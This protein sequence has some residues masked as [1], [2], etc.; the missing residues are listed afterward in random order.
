MH[1]QKYIDNLVVGDLFY[2]NYFEFPCILVGKGTEFVTLHIYNAASRKELHHI[3]I[4]DFVMSFNFE[5][6]S[7]F[8]RYA[9]TDGQPYDVINTYTKLLLHNAR[10]E[11]E[12][13]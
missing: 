2:M 13:K 10:K 4:K 7:Y 5:R 6:H 11:L 12:L 3:K 8:I 1:V 9:L